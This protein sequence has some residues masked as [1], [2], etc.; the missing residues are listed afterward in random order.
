MA[1]RYADIIIPLNFRDFVTYSVPEELAGGI[2]PGSIVNVLLAGKSCNGVVVKLTDRPSFTEGE[3]KPIREIVNLPPISKKNL[4]FLQQVAGYYICSPSDVFRFAAPSTTK[5]LKTKP[6]PK[7]APKKSRKAATDTTNEENLQGTNADQTTLPPLN[8]LTAPTLTN[9]QRKALN[10]IHELM[11]KGK[12]TLLK[13]VTG[14]GKTEIYI[15]I[16]IEELKKGRSVLYLVPEIAICRQI[17]IRLKKIFGERLL[18]FHSGKTAQERRAVYQEIAQAKEPYLVLG[19]RSALFLPYS[20]LGAII[21]DEEHDASYKQSEPAPRYHGRDTALMLGK[22]LGAPVILGSATP[23]FETIYNVRTGK[24]AQVD[25][26]EQYFGESRCR[27]RIVNMVSERRKNAVRGSLSLTLIK[28]IQERLDRGEQCLIFRS[29]RAYATVSECPECGHTPRCPKC[30]IPLAYHKFN[31]R[32]ACHICGYSE[33]AQT[34]CPNCGKGEMALFG[35]G[36]EKI[37]EELAQH[38]PAAR[39]DRF[40]SDT[41][42]DKRELEA[43]IKRFSDGQTDIL[44]GTQMV[45]KG[46]DFAKL[47]LTAVIKAEALSSVF[48]FRADERTLQLLRQ[49]KGRAGRRG[50]DS[51]MIIQ[52]LRAEHPVF[53]ALMEEQPEQTDEN[54]LSERSEFGFPPFVRLVKITVKSPDEEDLHR[55]CDR[56]GEAL[57]KAGVS[58]FSGPIAPPV[59]RIEGEFIMQFLVKLPRTSASAATKQ[60]LYRELRFIPRRHCIIDVDPVSF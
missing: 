57:R 45:S 16:A 2:V 26:E 44:V 8:A 29:R 53:H 60:A 28:A 41:T 48:D 52:T 46:F 1:Y 36:T 38:F 14:S 32:L 9:A 22:V 56:V 33:T 39:I 40:D 7:K 11:L 42:K 35:A 54:L 4:D 55:L 24:F 6:E 43:I 37:E 31:H 47:T 34:I 3:I 13:G 50:N 18:V 12:T 21:V 19:L 25:L 5:A 27:I 17:Q 59:S 15:N 23:S 20:K 30:N 49:L 10:E 51:E 58:D